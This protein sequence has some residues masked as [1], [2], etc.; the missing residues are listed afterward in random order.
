[1][2]RTM[3][4]I[5]IDIDLRKVGKDVSEAIFEPPNCRKV[6]CGNISKTGVPVRM[7]R[8]VDG[9]AIDAIRCARLARER[10]AGGVLFS[11]SAYFMKHSPRQ[12]TD[13]EAFST[14]EEFIAGQ[15]DE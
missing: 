6:F 12:F 1:M 10:G 14:T 5:N 7:G 3:G 4:T 9:V 15:R 11:P 13:D 8:I 2:R